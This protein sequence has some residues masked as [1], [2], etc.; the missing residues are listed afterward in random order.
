MAAIGLPH[1][2]S[3]DPSLRLASITRMVSRTPVPWLPPESHAAARSPESTDLGT[4]LPPQR[5][6]LC[7]SVEGAFVVH[8][9][10][11]RILVC[12]VVLDPAEGARPTKLA[13][14]RRAGGGAP[15][16]GVPLTPLAVVRA[17]R[18]PSLASAER[19][20]RSPPAACSRR[21]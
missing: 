19:L 8:E 21:G 9:V 3:H 10:E 6:G 4:L 7:V 12:E 20:G 13:V 14:A 2:G 18:S 5:D 17:G 16:R 11:A 15:S 1:S